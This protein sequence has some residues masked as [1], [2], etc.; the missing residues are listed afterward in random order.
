MAFSRALT[1]R[2]NP[3]FSVDFARVIFKSTYV[4][5]TLNPGIWSIWDPGDNRTDNVFM[6]DWNTTGPGVPADATCLDWVT[7]LDATEAAAF[8]IS[9]AVG[10][11]FANWVDMEFLL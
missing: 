8:N 11:D 6:A 4:T 2:D 9:T 5:A 1:I 7:I 3:T 10:D